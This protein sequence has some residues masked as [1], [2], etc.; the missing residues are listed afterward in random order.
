[1][2]ALIKVMVHDALSKT[3]IKVYLSWW[4]L[5]LL[6]S[7][8]NPFELYSVSS[9][10]Y[11][12]LMLNVFMFSF[13]FI[14]YGIIKPKPGQIYNINKSF[15]S[16]VLNNYKFKIVL[17]FL[18]VA[19][20]YF[21]IKYLSVIQ[22]VG[23]SEGRSTLFEI[24]DLFINKF[25]IY[26]FNLIVSPFS[27]YLIIVL[28]S[29]ILF[30]RKNILLFL[31]LVFVIFYGYIGTGRGFYVNILISLGI[32]FL[33]KPKI[34]AMNI[35][36]LSFKKSTLSKVV[37]RKVIV[38]LL[39]VFVVIMFS[40]TTAQRKG[41][42]DF[43]SETLFLGLNEFGKQSIWY[44]TGPFR[45]LDYAIANNYIEKTGLFYGRATFAG[46]DDLIKIFIHG[47]GGT[48]KSANDV[49]IPLIQDNRIP[50]S[51]EITFNFA[52][53]NVMIHLFDFGLLGVFLFPFV[54]GL[55]VRI[56][57][58][59]FIE[60]PTFPMLVI[61]IYIL[62]TMILTIFKWQYQFG[63]SI[64]LMIILYLMHK[65]AI[66]KNREILENIEDVVLK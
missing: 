59:K 4:V 32:V 54:F 60:A 17:V 31:C 37:I 18:L 43:N 57:Y 62:R 52:Y 9:K 5:W 45:A 10:V 13:G 23:G 30:Q 63:D 7:T 16:L 50:I 21:F 51:S 44:M 24:G 53:T 20:C 61:I 65:S 40:F 3:S 46:F 19:V 64:I 36:S 22:S 15:N 47:F 14:L 41:Y 2:L 25:E 33:I 48:Y 12:L 26:L 66:K 42:S 11:L 38:I 27:E 56:M 8:L 35:F 49:I 58:Y 6:I 29:L 28:I 34:I 39:V 1:M 55:F